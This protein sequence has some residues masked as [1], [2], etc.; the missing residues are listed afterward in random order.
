MTG[1]VSIIY[2][3]AWPPNWQLFWCVS[4]WNGKQ[5]HKRKRQRISLVVEHFESSVNEGFGLHC[6]KVHQNHGKLLQRLSWQSICHSYGSGGVVTASAVG[7]KYPKYQE[8]SFL[9]GAGYPHLPYPCPSVLQQDV[10]HFKLIQ[11]LEKYL[12]I[13]WSMR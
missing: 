6:T 7:N 12:N 13:F 11:P 10:L 3:S 5:N 9:L 8:M 4:N 1:A 2:F